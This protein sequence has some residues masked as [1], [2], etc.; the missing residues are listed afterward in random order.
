LIAEELTFKLRLN[1]NGA[2]NVLAGP[3]YAP[4]TVNQTPV[5]AYTYGTWANITATITNSGIVIYLN[6]AAIGT[7]GGLGGLGGI[8][9]FPFNIG[10]HNGDGSDAFTGKIG[11]VKV[12]SYG[13]TA[14]EVADDYAATAARYN[15]PPAADITG[16]FL[17][18][19]IDNKGM[20]YGSIGSALDA[21]GIDILQFSPDAGNT[22]FGLIDGTYTGYTIEA[23]YPYRSAFYVNSTR[24]ESITVTI[25]G[26]TA[27]LTHVDAYADVGDIFNLV[28]RVG[29]TLPI[30]I[31]FN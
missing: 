11:E 23:N 5:T 8:D 30:S 4:W 14:Q 13:L 10:C 29:Q 28:A 20:L 25:G 31:T 3:G 21:V 12:Y 24:V 16:S 6:G 1:P 26:V 18:E 17:V 7:Y 15:P 9:N 27:T 19:S 22:V 2:I